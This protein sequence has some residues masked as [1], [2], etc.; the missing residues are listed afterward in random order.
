MRNTP[1]STTW[2]SM[3]FTQEEWQAVVATWG[4]LVE[5]SKVVFGKKPPI[6]K[7]ISVLLKK[8]S[9]SDYI[10]AEYLS[11]GLAS[12]SRKYKQL[13]Y[14]VGKWS[15]QPH[16][17]EESAITEKEDTAKFNS[18]D[19]AMLFNEKP[20]IQ[21]SNFQS[22]LTQSPNKDNSSMI[23]ANDTTC[24]DDKQENDSTLIDM[25]Q[26]LSNQEPEHQYTEEQLAQS[27][28]IQ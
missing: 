26:I 25:H 24:P 2:S 19:E 15:R 16:T 27:V 22:T 14:E 28:T 5:E 17:Q 8:L 7:N 4:Q 3:S 11:P 20:E 23:A 18:E 12:S 21:N 10:F 9:K 6:A 13:Q 1:Q